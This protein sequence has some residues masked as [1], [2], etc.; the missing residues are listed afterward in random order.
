MI[1]PSEVSLPCSHVLSSLEENT[2]PLLLFDLCLPVQNQGKLCASTSSLFSFFL[3]LSPQSSQSIESDC[4]ISRFEK[5]APKILIYSVNRIITTNTHK[6]GRN[7][8]LDLRDT[9]DGSLK[10]GYYTRKSPTLSTLPTHSFSPQNQI[11]CPL[12]R[13]L[14]V[15][16]NS[17]PIERLQDVV[18][19]RARPSFLSRIMIRKESKINA[20]AMNAKLRQRN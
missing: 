20:K 14:F 1:W 18:D 5:R 7:R 13:V 2:F 12:M 16:G 11:I 3:F 9:T 8:T 19:D 4:H 15:E 6:L 17:I 10:R